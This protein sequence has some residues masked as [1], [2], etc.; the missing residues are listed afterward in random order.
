MTKYDVHIYAV[1]R[2]CVK[3]VDAQDPLDAIKRAEE[4]IDL[5]EVLD[6]DCQGCYTEYAEDV[7]SYLVDEYDVEG[8]VRNTKVFDKNYN[9]VS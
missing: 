9:P 8:E 6:R 1:V 5:H 2:V 4:S 7:E 3:G